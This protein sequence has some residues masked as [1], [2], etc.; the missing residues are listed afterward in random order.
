MNVKNKIDDRDTI[1]DYFSVIA[2]INCLSFGIEVCR[3][4]TF[5]SR[6]I[7]LSVSGWVSIKPKLFFVVESGFGLASNRIF[8]F[9]WDSNPTRAGLYF[10]SAP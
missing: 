3:V 4:L 1:V 9:G 7:I 10:C 8:G 5:E 6:E 2:L